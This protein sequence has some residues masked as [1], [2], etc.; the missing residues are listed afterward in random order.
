M[1]QGWAGGGLAAPHPCG[2]RDPQH[3]TAAVRAGGS[4]TS[5][6]WQRYEQDAE[7]GPWRTAARRQPPGHDVDTCCAAR[8][9][10]DFGGARHRGGPAR[11]GPADVGTPEPRPPAMRNFPRS[12]TSGGPVR[13][14]HAAMDEARVCWG[15][16]RDGSP[17]LGAPVPRQVPA[18]RSNRPTGSRAGAAPPTGRSGYHETKPS[19]APERGSPEQRAGAAYVALRMP[20][21]REV[22]PRQTVGTLQ[23]PTSARPKGTAVRRQCGRR[24]RRGHIPCRCGAWCAPDDAT[25]DESARTQVN[26]RPSRAAWPGGPHVRGPDGD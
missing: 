16:G 14:T 7:R 1:R 21:A 20:G 18:T 11:P 4:L 22:A 2:G 25:V 5:P 19:A 10:R 26:G 9:C 24:H 8:S 3:A 13:A 17:C 6:E 23:P 15:T 12:T